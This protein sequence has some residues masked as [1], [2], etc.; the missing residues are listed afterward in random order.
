MTR[1]PRWPRRRIS[2]APWLALTAL[3]AGMPACSSWQR[4]LS[5]LKEPRLSLAGLSVTDA[6]LLAP[7]FRV[8]LRVDNPNDRDISIQG[9]DLDLAINGEAVARGVSAGAVEL[10]RRG[11]SEIEV[12]ARAQ[13]LALARQLLAIDGGDTVKYGLSGHLKLLNWLGALGAVPFSF[14]GEMAREELLKGPENLRGL[15]M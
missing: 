9:A 13:T 11:S 8:R 14:R 6:N 1:F 10:V 12:D 3:M 7:G 4:E 2:I 5:E 15:G